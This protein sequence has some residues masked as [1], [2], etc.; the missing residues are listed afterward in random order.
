MSSKLTLVAVC[1]FEVALILFVVAWTAWAN[2]R[3]QDGVVYFDVMDGE[4]I[5][6]EGKILAKHVSRGKN[7]YNPMFV[8][9]SINYSRGPI[10]RIYVCKQAD[11]SLICR[12]YE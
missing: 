3:S 1:A 6:A 7:V 4:V 2:Q 12:R 9:Y 5:L 11:L 8:T 10:K